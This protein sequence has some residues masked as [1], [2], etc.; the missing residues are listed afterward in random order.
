MAVITPST[1]KAQ[2]TGVLVALTTAAWLTAAGCAGGPSLDRALTIE[3]G[4][5]TVVHL[6][7]FR[8]GR[9]FTVQN[10]S[11]GSQAEVY[12][13][14]RTNTMTKVVDDEMLQRLLDVFAEKGLFAVASSAVPAEASDALVVQQG[15]RRFVFTRHAFPRGKEQPFREAKAYFLTVY[16]QA[17]AYHTSKI[18]RGDLE[19]ESERAQSSGSA[20]RGK[21]E[22]LKGRRK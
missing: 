10:A 17:T 16:N 4:R 2:R 18:H 19:N 5:R 14:A 3:S 6:M 15:D 1:T 8:D 12:S 11:S 21:L 7:Q 9:V 20:A 13:D 22:Q